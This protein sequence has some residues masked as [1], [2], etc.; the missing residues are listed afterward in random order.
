MKITSNTVFK[1]S[2]LKIWF[3]LHPLKI[4]A[5]RTSLYG[6]FQRIIYTVTYKETLHIPLSILNDYSSESFILK[7]IAEMQMKKN[8]KTSKSKT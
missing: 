5:R 4:L 8:L 6:K 1:N 2:E 7:I 3:F